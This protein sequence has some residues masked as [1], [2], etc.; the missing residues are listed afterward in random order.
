[1]HS[2]EWPKCLETVHLK[3][4]LTIGG[5]C[6][7]KY[8][9]SAWS[10]LIPSNEVGYHFMKCVCNLLQVPLKDLPLFS[11]LFRGKPNVISDYQKVVM[12]DGAK[13]SD[14]IPKSC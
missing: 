3:R 8:T 5:E 14:C 7:Q 6:G 12:F 4:N 1:M 9:S 2:S 10:L 11:F 13:R